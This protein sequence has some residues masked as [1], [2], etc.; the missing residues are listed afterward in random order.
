MDWYVSVRTGLPGAG[1]ELLQRAVELCGSKRP[2]R[3]EPYKTT[4]LSPVP[5][6]F[7]TVNLN[8]GQSDYPDISAVS[9]GVQ[10]GHRVELRPVVTITWS[11]DQGLGVRG[12]CRSV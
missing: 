7:K 9:L 10:F 3:S 4:D 6:S 11:V 2:A 12:E 5:D 1:I 8:P